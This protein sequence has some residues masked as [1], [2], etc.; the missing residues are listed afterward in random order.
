MIM[1][2]GKRYSAEPNELDLLDS[3]AG[4][5]GQNEENLLTDDPPSTNE[6]STPSNI[7]TWPQNIKRGNDGQLSS[8]KKSSPVRTKS[9][10]NDAKRRQ[11]RLDEKRIEQARMETAGMFKPNLMTSGKKKGRAEML[12]WSLNGN[13]PMSPAQQP[14]TPEAKSTIGTTVQSKNKASPHQRMFDRSRQINMKKEERIRKQFEIEAAINTFK[15]TIYT[16]PGANKGKLVTETS[17]SVFDRL[18]RRAEK[19]RKKKEDLARELTAQQCSFSPNVN[20]KVGNHGV[21]SRRLSLKDDKEHHTPSKVNTKELTSRL[22]NPKHLEETAKRKEQLKI[23]Y[24]TKE[25][26]YQPKIMKPGHDVTYGVTT[27]T[28]SL[29]SP[30]ATRSHDDTKT[31]PTTTAVVSPVRQEEACLRLYDKANSQNKQFEAWREEAKVKNL[32]ECTFA[33]NLSDSTRKVQGKLGLRAAKDVF[34]RL[35]QK[36]KKVFLRAKDPNL[37][38]TPK[39]NEKK[40]IDPDSE[41]AAL[42]QMPLGE[43]FDRLYQQGVD[44]I[45]KKRLLPKDESKA[46]KK[47]LEDEELKNCT[48]KPKTTWKKVFGQNMG[49]YNEIE[50]NEAGSFEFSDND[51]D[52]EFH[53]G[54]EDEWEEEEVEVPDES[55]GEGEEEGGEEGEGEGGEEE[56]GEMTAGLVDILGEMRDITGSDLDDEEEE[57]QVQLEVEPA[58]ELAAENVLEA[59]PEPAAEPVTEDLLDFGITDQ[60]AEEWVESQDEHGNVYYTNSTTGE[61]SWTQGQANNDALETEVFEYDTELT[62][63]EGGATDLLGLEAAAADLRLSD[64]TNEGKLSPGSIDILGG[65]LNDNDFHYEEEEGAAADFEHVA[66]HTRS[67]D[68]MESASDVSENPFF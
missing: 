45:E 40:L 2:D 55:E 41:L 50:M 34:E 13:S 31:T 9:L 37:T 21:G 24:E 14:D 43:R 30:P 29:N 44:R 39:I 56:V 5:D 8:N 47:K 7:V 61:T 26:T 18:D 20:K 35:T 3:L 57:Q 11:Q 4:G 16:S 23:E 36:E 10:Y 63:D 46:I 51:N 22:Y 17:G 64:N 42:T 25:C 48:F 1:R 12:E 53:V 33:P 27:T 28:L 66:D 68:K 67:H 49:S 15:P 6:P 62:N 60:S 52:M 58:S 38:F 54:E 65:G 19:I 59:V 32:T